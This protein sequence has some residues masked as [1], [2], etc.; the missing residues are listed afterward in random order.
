MSKALPAEE[1][2]AEEDIQ[3]TFQEKGKKV[4]I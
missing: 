1:K 2:E 3:P 4:P